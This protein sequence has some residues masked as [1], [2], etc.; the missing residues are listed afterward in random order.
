[1]NIDEK[2]EELKK[3]LNRVPIRAPPEMVLS[4]N[5]NN[6]TLEYASLNSNSYFFPFDDSAM[7]YSDE[8]NFSNNKLNFEVLEDF[9]K[10]LKGVI[11]I[12]QNYYEVEQISEPVVADTVSGISLLTAIIFAFL[13]NFLP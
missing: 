4:S 5:E 12:G 8:Q 10:S 11:N 3:W 1:M 13:D 6:F 9:N 7:N 2:P